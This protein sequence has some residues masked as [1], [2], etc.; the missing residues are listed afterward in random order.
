MTPDRP[1]TVVYV[2]TSLDGFIAR[3]DGGIDW[4]DLPE[5]ES[6]SEGPAEDYGWAEFIATIDAMVMGRATFELLLG[7]DTWHYGEIPVTVLSRTLEA[8]PEHLAGKARVSS[9]GPHEV[10][11]ELAGQGARRVYVDG[12]R[13]VQSFLALDLIDELVVTRLPIL[14]GEGIP[15]FGPL[16]GDLRW[17]HRSTRVY[18]AGGLV[19]ST[20]RRAR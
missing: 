13:A 1:Q 15:L 17:E 4:L 2:G 5:P 11:A 18:E 7:L 9:L 3:P 14:I 19:K 20:Y 6:D 8:V 12:G 16:D 10:L